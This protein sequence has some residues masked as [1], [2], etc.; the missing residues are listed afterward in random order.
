M[1]RR[2]GTIGAA[3]DIT[4]GDPV[5]THVLDRRPDALDVTILD[6]GHQ[7]EIEIMVVHAG[8]RAHNPHDMKETLSAKSRQ[9][10]THLHP[11]HT[12]M[13]H[14]SHEASLR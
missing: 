11:V 5:L 12:E 4:D 10:Q 9:Y 8:T 2:I 7:D 13:A 14:G 6:R 3:E 1:R